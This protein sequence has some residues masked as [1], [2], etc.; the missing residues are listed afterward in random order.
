MVENHGKPIG[1]MFYFAGGGEKSEGLRVIESGKH[2]PFEVKR[3]FWRNMEYGE[4][5]GGHAHK[6][7]QQVI[8]CVS[9]AI[10]IE[11]AGLDPQTNVV[12]WRA[13]PIIEAG[14]AGIL[15]E[16]YVYIS[17]EPVNGDPASIIVFASEP[18]DE[19]DYI[20]ALDIRKAE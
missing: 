19:K 1:V 9:G 5:H 8:Y 2:L 18:Y 3:V 7:C 4:S 11:M 6:T 20:R 13:K 12:Q 10:A 14:M 17:Y 15:I 16:P